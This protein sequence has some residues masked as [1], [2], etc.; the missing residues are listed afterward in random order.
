MDFSFVGDGKQKGGGT[1]LI[2]GTCT[3]TNIM[4]W[5]KT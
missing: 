2:A 3:C 4:I 1:R 5:E